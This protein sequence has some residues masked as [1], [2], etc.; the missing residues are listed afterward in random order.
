MFG[1]WVALLALKK[2]YTTKGHI[3]LCTAVCMLALASEVVH[4]VLLGSPFDGYDMLATILAQLLM[5][6]LPILTRDKYF[7]AYV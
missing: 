3:V 5:V 6:F 1:K 2:P 4:D 7:H